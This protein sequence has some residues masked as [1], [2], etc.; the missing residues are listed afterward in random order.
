M[1]FFTI[2]MWLGLSI[3]LGLALEPVLAFES[4]ANLLLEISIGHMILL[5]IM[6]WTIVLSKK[7]DNI[8]IGSRLGTTGYLHTLIGTSAALIAASSFD[9]NNPNEIQQIIQPIGAALGTSIIGWWMGKEIQRSVWNTKK[10]TKKTSYYEEVE[11][12][13]RQLASSVRNLSKK[14]EE[15]GEKW[16][17]SVNQLGEK[18][19]HAEQK[20]G[21]I[22]S[23]LTRIVSSS[24]TL[25]KNLSEAGSHMESATTASSKTASEMKTL[26]D[27]AKSTATRLNETNESLKNVNKIIAE[28]DKLLAL[29]RQERNS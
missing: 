11:K 16:E 28:A 3:A 20:M 2:L 26:A 8:E 1:S 22:N 10:E 18:I 9:G 15:S 25:A 23:N 27:K 12:S 6:A 29:L 4:Q 19:N 24:A 13:F 14:L 17:T 5:S 21:D 7:G